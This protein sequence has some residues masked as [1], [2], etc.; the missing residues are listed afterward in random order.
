MKKAVVVVVFG[1]LFSKFLVMAGMA[2]GQLVPAFVWGEPNGAAASQQQ[3]IE[4]QF[5]VASGKRLKID[6]KTGGSLD[7]TGWDSEQVAVN[8]TLGG[9]DGRDAEVTFDETPE[10]LEIHSRFTERRKS[11]SSN[12][13]FEIKVPRR[14]DISLNTMGGGV[15]I[16]GVE[17]RFNGQ[18]M[19]GEL[20]LS[21]LAGTVDLKTMGGAVTLKNSRVDGRVTTMGGEVLIEDVTG[22]VRGHTMGGKV[23]H[24]NVKTSAGEGATGEVRISTMGGEINV[25]E[26]PAGA[27]VS[28]MGGDIRIR[29]AGASV[30]AKTMGGRIWIGEVNGGARAT[31]MG[32]DIEVRMVGNPGEGNRDVE[33]TS[34]GG[35]ITL[36]V[37]EGLSM[38]VSIELAHTRNA[39]ETYSITSDFPLAQRESPDWIYDQGTPRKV[40]YGTGNIA[41]G[42]HKIRLKTINGNVQLKRG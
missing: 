29:T 9:R 5:T 27:N 42:R 21:D 37:P 26:A 11:R 16:A 15:R 38:D 2:A 39:R 17:G 18:T 34:M 32:G 20:D 24:R 19:G 10:G 14:F 41:G 36:T 25:E 23:T 13:R 3:Q 40:I 12:L 1:F 4:R 35:D 33:L 30:Y 7:I 22:D 28:T 6:L 8:A 31:T